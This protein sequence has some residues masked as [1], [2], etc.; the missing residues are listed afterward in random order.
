MYYPGILLDVLSETLCTSPMV[1][2][3]PTEIQTRYFQDK[4]L[5][6]YRNTSLT[7]MFSGFLIKVLQL[8]NTTKE[9]KMRT[10]FWLDT[11]KE[12][13]SHKMGKIK[14]DL[15]ELKC[16]VQRIHEVQNRAHFRDY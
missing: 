9:F 12:K 7:A 3:N 11:R 8:N 2:V 5:Q 16:D 4:S 15:K 1:V 13:T 10:K 14:M 6:C